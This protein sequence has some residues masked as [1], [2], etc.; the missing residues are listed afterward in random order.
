MS[1]FKDDEV[2]FD[3]DAC[4]ANMTFVVE[5]L[6]ELLLED[7]VLKE[8]TNFHVR[9]DPDQSV[10]AAGLLELTG[11]PIDT[12]LPLSSPFLQ[13]DGHALLNSCNISGTSK[14][15]N[16]DRSSMELVYSEVWEPFVID[17][18]PTST[19]LLSQMTL[20][21]NFSYPSTSFDCTVITPDASRFYST[22]DDDEE[23]CLGSETLVA[24]EFLSLETEDWYDL[25]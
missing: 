3:S 19:I 20:Y 23:L 21:E 14:L 12:T 9:R 6:G 13:N 2:L 5:P 17:C 15:S 24:S 11:C 16:G 25:I 1:L 18:V 7:I 8:K 4:F 22:V 10:D